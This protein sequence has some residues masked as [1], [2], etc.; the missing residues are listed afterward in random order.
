M[1]KEI[2][3][4]VV[5]LTA[6]LLFIVSKPIINGQSGND[7]NKIV[8]LETSKGNV[9]VQL[10]NV[11][12]PI[13]TANF[14]RY[15]NEGFYNGTIFHRV[16][17]GFMAQGGGFTPN[18]TEKQTHEAIKLESNNGL[19]NK[20][21]TIAMARTSVPDSATSQFFINAVDNSFLDYA[22]GNDGYAVFGSVTKGM[23]VVDSILSVKTGDRGS[24]SDWPLQD[25]VIK[26]A[27]VKK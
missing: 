15:V 24:F 6:V 18:G 22:H 23:E 26:G 20:R 12:A 1:K 9:E 27:Y 17:P 11:N 4:G 5:L 21:G 2:V 19:K 7:M 16:M 25:I 14:L 8:V 13:T 3:I 10:D